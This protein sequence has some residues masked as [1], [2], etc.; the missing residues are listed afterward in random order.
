MENPHNVKITLTAHDLQIQ[1]NRILFKVRFDPNDYS[2]AIHSFRSNSV[3]APEQ[4]RITYWYTPV[5]PS[6]QCFVENRP[7]KIFACCKFDGLTWTPYTPQSWHS[8]I[9]SS[10][11]FSHDYYVKA[12]IAHESYLH[13]S[14]SFIF[15]W[16]RDMKNS[17][18]SGSY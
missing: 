13:S 17:M 8:G 15:K 2:L 3:S 1:L 4:T 7:T 18:W 6:L 14:D 5:Y 12:H 9:C 16:Y 11:L 10:V